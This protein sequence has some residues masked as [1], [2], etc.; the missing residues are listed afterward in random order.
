MDFL[1]ESPESKFKIQFLIEK[2]QDYT[3][4]VVME[5]ISLPVETT[6]LNVDGN[7]MSAKGFSPLVPSEPIEFELTFE[8]EEFHGRIN[9][10]YQET[11]LV[12]G[13][14]GAGPSLMDD[15]IAELDHTK[16]KTYINGMM[17]KFSNA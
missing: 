12:R 17:K 14:R 7:V 10:P 3:L 9:F 5:P 2:R 1:F 6:T 13:A 11:I 16:S 15:L 4:S 8:K